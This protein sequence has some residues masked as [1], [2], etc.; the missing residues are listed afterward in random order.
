MIFP[1]GAVPLSSYQYRR[2]YSAIRLDNVNCIGMEDHL[3]NC[4]HGG[5]GVRR[6][7]CSYYNGVECAVGES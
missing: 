3:L 5:I 1:P 4:S 7:S 6:Y 2:V